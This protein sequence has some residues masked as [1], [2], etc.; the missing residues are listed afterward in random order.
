MRV[1]L[2]ALALALSTSTAMAAAPVEIPGE[3]IVRFRHDASA[4]QRSTALA[5][6]PAATRLREFAF[7][8]A[9]LVRF[10][11]MS[12]DAAVAELQKDPDVLYAEPNYEIHIARVPNDRRFPE[13]YAM[14]NVGQTGGTPGA[15]IRATLAWDLF[16]GDPNLKV[17]VIDTGIDYT[18]PDLAA[19]IWTNPGE[20]PGN[21]IDDDHN[22]YIDDIHGWDAVH[23]DGDPMDDH[24]HGTHCSGTIA[25]AGD[26]GVGVAGVNWHLKL[27]AIKFL[28]AS[29]SGSTAGAIE[30]VQYA[31]AAGVRLTSNSWGG[32]PYSAA[33][34]DAINA[35][36]AAGQLFI[37]A[38]GND[39]STPTSSRS[40]PRATTRRTSSRWA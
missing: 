8:D 21:G 34:L 23:H 14:R 6:V 28:D 30:A 32:G 9:A 27:V 22:G 17:G 38:A 1:F 13:L 36:G 18:H 3:V 33:L 10:S 31:I 2:A 37:A 29:G 15:D 19:N 39:G 16:T 7:I 24:G 5:R 4:A 35:A 26:N 25:G 11:S 12:T 40:T 20:I